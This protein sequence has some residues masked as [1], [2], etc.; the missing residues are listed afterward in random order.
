MLIVYSRYE[1][2]ENIFGKKIT[3]LSDK[4]ILKGDIKIEIRM[5][6][7]MHMSL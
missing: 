4:N 7:Y 2:K 1:P 6:M 3:I 5:Y